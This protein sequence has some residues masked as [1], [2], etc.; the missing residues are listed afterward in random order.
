MPT[1]AILTISDSRSAGT[2]TDT[3]TGLMT[4][5]LTS[6]EIEI[7]QTRLVPDEH[8]EIAAAIV[9]LAAAADL[10]LTSGGTGLAPRDVTPEA[11]RA[12]IDREAPGIAEAMRSETAKLQRLSWLSRGVA[13][14]RGR[15]LVVNLPGNPKAVR[16][17]LDV[18]APMLPHA[19]RLATG[20]DEQHA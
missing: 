16:E 9:A 3:T 20:A 12:V 17:C 4:E 19:L 13:G 11:T 8:D 2:R 6:L 15:S 10:V 14:T 5:I 1:A 7:V 18:L